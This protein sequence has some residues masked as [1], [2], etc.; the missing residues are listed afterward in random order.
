MNVCQFTGRLTAAP[1]RKDTETTARCF[2]TIMVNKEGKRPDGTRY[3][4]QAVDCVAWGKL[5]EH[6][7]KYKD[8]GHLVLVTTEFS[9]YEVSPIDMNNQPVANARKYQRPIFTVRNI[10]FMPVNNN[11]NN[12]GVQSYNN[13]SANNVA[14]NIGEIPSYEPS[15]FPVDPA[16][17]NGAL[18]FDFDSE[19]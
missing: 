17:N 16:S 15:D 5:C 11:G 6:I 1:R 3:P 9:T 18:P 8:K 12:N 13:D 2:F 19:K 10:E 4:A 7:C 14:E